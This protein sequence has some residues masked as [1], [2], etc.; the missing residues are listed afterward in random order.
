MSGV[1]KLT[2]LFDRIRICFRAEM[3]KTQME[4]EYGIFCQ[5][6]SWSAFFC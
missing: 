5:F 4:S 6:R 1:R 2:L 3:G